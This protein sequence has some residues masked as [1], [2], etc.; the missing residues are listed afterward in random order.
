MFKF[1]IVKLYNNFRFFTKE[2]LILR[3]IKLLNS[4]LVVVSGTRGIKL[5]S[6]P[7]NFTSVETNSVNGHFVFSG[8]SFFTML[9]RK[10]ST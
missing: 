10:Y 8:K 5:R 2:I 9:L 6:F 3:L 1:E 4:N 7:I